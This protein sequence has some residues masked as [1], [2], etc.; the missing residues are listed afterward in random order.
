[1]G[2]SVRPLSVKDGLKFI[3][4][5][6]YAPGPGTNSLGSLRTTRPYIEY[7]GPLDP[8]R[9][10][11][12]PAGPGLAWVSRTGSRPCSETRPAFAAAWPPKGG[13]STGRCCCRSYIL[14]VRRGDRE[15][16]DMVSPCKYTLCL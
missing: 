4:L 3:I 5:G 12:Y 10:T 15:I 14:T 16:A 8:G 7:E 9:A 1:L 2:P 13:D 11:V 6:W